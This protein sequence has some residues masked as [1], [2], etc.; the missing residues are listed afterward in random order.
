MVVVAAGV[1][2]A[3]GIELA[4]ELLEAQPA[5]IK[6]AAAAAINKPFFVVFFILF[7]L[8]RLLLKLALLYAEIH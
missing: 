5:N 7:I 1:E 6:P 4:F 8:V 2:L 3:A